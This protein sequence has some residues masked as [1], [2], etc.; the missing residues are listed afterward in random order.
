MRIFYGICFLL[1]GL[2]SNG[3]KLLRGIVLDAQKNTPIPN[4]SVFLNTTSVG[5][6]TN[7]Q[8]NFAMTIP[9]GKYE[10]IISSIGYETNTQIISSTDAPEFVTVKLKIKAEVMQTVII[11]PYE[12]DGWTKWGKFFVESFIGTS[13][14]AKDCRIK[15]TKVIKFRHSK[16]KNE[17]SAFADEPLII[18]NRALGYTIRY[19][20]E[21]FQYDFKTGYLLYAGY[22]F[23]QPMKGNS[24]RQKRW[25]NM[26][27]EVYAGS[28]MHFMRA[29]YRNKTAE[30]G[31]EINPLKKIPNAEKQRVKV[32]Y[33]TNTR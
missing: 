10:L 33:S 13:S 31:F 9:N 15:N 5:T 28:I 20:M 30:E 2:V 8:G 32:A 18:E 27:S 29:V 11:E 22:P 7:E 16:T 24:A 21:A 23:F 19:Q 25:E 17:L 26:R 6:V 1:F 14:L 3:Q 12:K 4:A